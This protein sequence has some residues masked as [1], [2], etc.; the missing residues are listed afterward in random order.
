[1]EQSKIDRINELARKSR[2]AELSEEEKD[3]QKALRE[4][5]VNSF[6]NN[7]RSTLDTLVI[8]DEDGNRKPLKK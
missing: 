2:T 8:V 1:M 4:E 6:R 7:L 5:Y 3:E